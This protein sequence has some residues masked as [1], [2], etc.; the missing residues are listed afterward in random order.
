M[1]IGMFTLDYLMA[2]QLLGNT[3]TDTNTNTY[4]TN[5]IIIIENI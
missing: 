5:A 2:S 4:N 3:N 1:L